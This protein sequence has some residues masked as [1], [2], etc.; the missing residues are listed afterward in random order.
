MHAP[1]VWLGA[2]T[3]GA[4]G[5]QDSVARDSWELLSMMHLLLEVVWQTVVDL[6]G[7]V[8]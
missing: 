3:G 2:C 8:I 7:N 1:S 4:C 6:F 5:D